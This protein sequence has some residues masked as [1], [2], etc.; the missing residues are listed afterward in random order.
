VYYTDEYPVE[1]PIVIDNPNCPAN[2][3]NGENTIR[4]AIVSSKLCVVLEAGDNAAEIRSTLVMGLSEAI[5][6]GEFEDL[7]PQERLGP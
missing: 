6:S 3:A 7:I 1:I 2:N 4:C 5:D